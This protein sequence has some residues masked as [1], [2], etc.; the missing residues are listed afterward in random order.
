M[1]FKTF[2]IIF[3][4]TKG[5]NYNIFK[6]LLFCLNIIIKLITILNINVIDQTYDY[7]YPYV[8]MKYCLFLFS[9]IFFSVTLVMA[10]EGTTQES[11]DI[12][13]IKVGCWVEY[14]IAI[15]DGINEKLVFN[16]F[17]KLYGVNGNM[18]DFEYKVDGIGKR[19]QISRNDF[20]LLKLVPKINRATSYKESSTETVVL[21][22]MENFK[23]ETTHDIWNYENGVTEAW[24]SKKVPFSMVR[25]VCKGFNMELRA[26]S[27][28][29]E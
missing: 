13:N 20:P 3:N 11:L 29:E 24:Y 6:L 16:C 21:A 10:N 27:W 19:I 28:A 9:I 14:H 7:M 17:I 4:S 23:V 18:L 1:Y 8:I 2:R 26:F 22:E 15:E 12:S 25:V 5:Y